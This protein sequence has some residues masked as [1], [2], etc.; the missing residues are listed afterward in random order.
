MGNIAVDRNDNIFIVIRNIIHIYDKIG[1]LLRKINLN[2]KL[3]IR[4]NI[5]SLVVDHST[6]EN[7]IICDIFNGY[8]MV[9]DKC[10]KYIC[11]S[12]ILGYYDMSCYVNYYSGN[13]RDQISILDKNCKLVKVIKHNMY[14][15]IR[16]DVFINQ[17][18]GNI[19][20][21][22]TYVKLINIYDHNGKL[23]RSFDVNYKKDT[24]FRI[25]FD[26][27]NS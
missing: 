23:L 26:N 25:K 21:T 9:F 27:C 17:N 2:N 1:T 19:I 22:D 8:L 4:I 18:N 16:N 12:G 7:I 13:N 20:T 5:D 10:G 15:N 14:R 24:F 3:K 11:R 6:D